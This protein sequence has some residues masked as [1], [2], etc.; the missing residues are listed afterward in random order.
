MKPTLNEK[1]AGSTRPRRLLF[2]RMDGE[3]DALPRPAT[4]PE[5]PDDH[6]ITDR[7]G[8]LAHFPD[9]LTSPV[10]EG[11]AV[12]LMQD[13]PGFCSMILRLDDAPEALTED[14]GV[15]PEMVVKMAGIVNDVCQ[16]Q[17]GMW[18]QTGCRGFRVCF[19][20][21]GHLPAPGHG[22]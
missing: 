3:P 12:L 17:K 9:M 4:D 16:K 5:T 8:L 15:S 14:L 19:S 22:G 20:G 10:Y 6:Q 1:Q 2:P 21:T 18:G 13:K 11:R 7:F